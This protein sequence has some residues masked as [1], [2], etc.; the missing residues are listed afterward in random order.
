MSETLEGV[1][2]GKT[3]EL[4]TDP[5]LVDGQVVQVI[6]KPLPT[7]DQRRDAILRTAGSMA[8][9]ADFDA[10]MSQVQAD[11]RSARYRETKG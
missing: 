10:A 2:R 8:N 7:P 5:G 1:I 6:V 3:I 11:R 9:D 4:A